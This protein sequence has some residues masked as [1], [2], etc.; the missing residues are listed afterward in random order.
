MD[1]CTKRQTQFP[2]LASDLNFKGDWLTTFN[3][4]SAKDL[5][6]LPAVGC[7]FLGV[8]EAL[9]KLLNC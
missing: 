3:L 6:E 4:Y 2:F 1:L 5:K 8:A 9:A 7:H